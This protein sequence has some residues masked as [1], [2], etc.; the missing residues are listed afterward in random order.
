MG[1]KDGAR[2]RARYTL[3]FN[4]EAVPLVQCGQDVG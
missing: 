2:H 4:L 3:E 1:R